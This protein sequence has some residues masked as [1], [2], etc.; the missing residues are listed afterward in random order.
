MDPSALNIVIAGAGLM[1]RWHAHAL[2]QLGFSIFAF[3]DSERGRAERL[4]S[5]YGPAKVETSLESL[6][7]Q[8]RVDAVHICTLPETHEALTRSALR[9]GAHTLV[10]K[11]FASSAA[12]ANELIGLAE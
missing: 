11:P 9:A 10:E 6:L 7:A 1:G 4:A 5:R 2:R 3:V 8:H 12:A